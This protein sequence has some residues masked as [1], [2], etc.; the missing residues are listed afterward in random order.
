[1]NGITHLLKTGQRL[2]AICVVDQ[3]TK[4]C[5]LAPCKDIDN[6]E[7]TALLFKDKCFR[8]HGWSSKV[9]RD[10]GLEFTNMFAAALMKALG[11]EH[12]KS[13]S[14]HPQSNGQTERMNRVLEDMLRHFV[15]P[16]KMIE[17][18]CCLCLSLK[19]TT[20]FSRAFRIHH[21]F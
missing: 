10:R 2:T 6:A 8:F 7:A 1:M 17:I 20:P 12:C 5:H 19:S 16:R 11:I 13:T 14:Y 15:N 18:P 21:S 9:I 4:M 3:L